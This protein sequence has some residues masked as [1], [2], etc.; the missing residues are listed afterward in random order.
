MTSKA[1]IT[2]DFP[3]PREVASRLRIPVDR[4]AELRRQLFDLYVTHPDGSITVIPVKNSAGG[5]KSR[6]RSSKKTS[7]ARVA[8][9][10]AKKK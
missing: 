4:A 1:R 10:P 5:A 6:G 3:T 7:A 2:S 8:K 9:A